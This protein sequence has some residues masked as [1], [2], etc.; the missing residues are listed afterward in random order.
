MVFTLTPVAPPLPSRTAWL[1]TSVT[2]VAVLALG[3]IVFADAARI[4]RLTI[5]NE[6]E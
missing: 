3:F 6:T 1:W 5:V 4:D 2:A